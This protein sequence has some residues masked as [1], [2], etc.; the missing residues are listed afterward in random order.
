MKKYTLDVRSETGTT[1]LKKVR[2]VVMAG[3][4]DR[5]V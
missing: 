3:S 1:V 2:V 4:S 5:P